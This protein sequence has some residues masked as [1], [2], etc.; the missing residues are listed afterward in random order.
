MFRIILSEIGCW[1]L[2]FQE[3]HF[4]R[5]RHQEFHPGVS[6]ISNGKAAAAYACGCV[7]FDGKR[8]EYLR[9]CIHA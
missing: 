5:A 4:S 7:A 1:V 9:K 2:I 3:K 6:R 8:C